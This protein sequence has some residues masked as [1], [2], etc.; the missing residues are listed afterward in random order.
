MLVCGMAMLNCLDVNK[1]VCVCVG[2][3]YPGCIPACVHR[4]GSGFNVPLT[5]IKEDELIKEKMN[6]E[7]NE[8]VS[9]IIDGIISRIRTN[10]K[11][12]I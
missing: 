2:V 3:Q 12:N 1:C 11:R 9:K 6:K 5:R 7:M 8:G 4:T 10:K